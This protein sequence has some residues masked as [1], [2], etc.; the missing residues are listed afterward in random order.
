MG[1]LCAGG[2]HFLC[3]NSLEKDYCAATGITLGAEAIFDLARSAQGDGVILSNVKGK[4]GRTSAQIA[5]RLIKHEW[6]SLVSYTVKKI[7]RYK[8]QVQAPIK[9]IL[10]GG[11]VDYNQDML[12]AILANM[13]IPPNIEFIFSALGDARAILGAVTYAK[14]VCEQQL[15]ASHRY[16]VGIDLGGTHIRVALVDLEHMRVVGDILKQKLFQ[17]SV[18]TEGI[19]DFSECMLKNQRLGSFSS[20]DQLRYAQLANAL[21]TTIANLVKKVASGKEIAFVALS[22]AGDIT[23]DGYCTRATFLPFSGVHVR[24]ELE[25]RVKHSVFIAHDI[26][27]GALGEKTVGAGKNDAKFVFVALGTF[28]GVQLFDSETWDCKNI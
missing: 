23:D 24:K 14:S 27:C 20:P 3:R 22:S 21:L 17:N 10:G 25:E 28:I 11:I 13:V 26:F 6:C 19:P 5:L 15:L 16:A 1:C 4:T 8:D 2:I 7:E 18:D 12:K 9:V